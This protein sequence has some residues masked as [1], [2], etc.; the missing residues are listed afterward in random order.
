[1]IVTVLWEDQR[2][3]QV[4]D[5][6]PDLL[7]RACVADDLQVPRDAVHWRLDSVPKKGNGNV[8][9]ALREDGGR[10]ARSGPVCAVLDRDKVLLLWSREQ[11]PANCKTG[12][13][14]A[15]ARDALGEPKVVLLEDNVETLIR[16]ACVAVASPSP[17]SKSSPLERD[18]ILSR[19]AWG[20][21][22]D[23]RK[24]RASVSSFDYLVKWTTEQVARII[25][26]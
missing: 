20:S 7:L 6:G 17:A 2:G 21:E 8:V 4:K 19:L 23:R 26:G 12:I 9:R 10:L 11:R 15:I 24:L 18:R 3:G 5:F 14:A 13:R 22:E 16:A 1:V 25:D